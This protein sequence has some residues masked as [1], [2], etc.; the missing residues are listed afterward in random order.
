MADEDFNLVDL[1]QQPRFHDPLSATEYLEG[2]RW[3]NGRSVPTVA[4]MSA[5]RI[6]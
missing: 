6:C 3:P 2:V 5:L 4:S 1:I